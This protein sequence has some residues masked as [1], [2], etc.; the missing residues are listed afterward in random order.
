MK[1][2]RIALAQINPIVGDIGGNTAKI[3]A[4]IKKAIALQSDIVTFPELSICGYPPE[5]LLLKHKFLLD[6]HRGLEAVVQACENITAVVG[7]ANFSNE[8]I[9]NSAALIHNKAVV[10]VYNKLELPNYGVFDEKR[11]FTPGQGCLV[12]EL[13]GIKVSVTICEDIWVENSLSEDCVLRNRAA[14]TLNISASPF[15][16]GKYELRKKVVG[17]FSKVT[18]SIVCFNNLVGGQ[19]ELVFDG[20]SLVI[21]PGEKILT[22]ANRFSEDLLVTDITV[23]AI[24]LEE[25]SRGPEKKI[26]VLGSSVPERSNVLSNRRPRNMDRVEEVFEALKLGLKDYCSKNRFTKLVIGLSGGI[27]SA[28]TTAIACESLGVQNVIGVTMPSRF[29]SGETLSDAGLLAKNLGIR[30]ISAPIEGILASFMDALKDTLG[31]GP[32]GIEY[33]NLQARIRGAILMT[34]SNRFGWLVLTTGNKSETA[35]GYCTL[36]GDMAGGFALIKDVPK[37]LVFEL[38]RYVNKRAGYDLIPQ[39]TIDRAPTAELRP[40][41]KDEDSLPPYNILDPILKAYVEDDKSPDEIRNF[42]ADIVKSVAHLVDINEYKRRQAPPGIKIT[43][44][45]F[46][47]DRRLPITNRYT[48]DNMDEK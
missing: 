27:D 4:N 26:V 44:K 3:V 45:A 8:K 16:S 14:L 28:L 18:G 23:D 43:P 34:L 6:N 12:F 39:S 1:T 41:Q 19:D 22:A 5:D 13:K 30:M 29:T 10:A 31:D 11:Y 2:L 7:Y 9:Y 38:S 40:D 20:G 42:P 17:R 32:L 36:Y 15:Y 35:V 46:G 37:T 33:E 48:N 47:R 24:P 21:S 25:S